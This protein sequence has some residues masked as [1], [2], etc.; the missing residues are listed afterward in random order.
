MIPAPRKALR[1]GASG[2]CTYA[3]FNAVDEGNAGDTGW[4]RDRIGVR[5]A[6]ARRALVAAL[7]STLL[8]SCGIPGPVSAAP[9][10]EAARCTTTAA[11]VN[12]WGTPNRQDDFND[13][14]LP[15]W[16]LYDGPGHD[17][18]GRRTPA[19]VSVTEGTLT[20]TGAPN[21]DSGGMGWDSGQMYGRWEVCARSPQAAPGYHSVL[22]LWPDAEDWPIGG[23]VDFMEAIDPTRQ[24]VE[25][26]LHYGAEDHRVGGAVNV[27]ATQ[28]HSWAVEWTPK[29]IT[30]YLNGN[31]WWTTTDIATFPPRALH[32]CLQVDN[33][34]G[35]IAA[36]GQQL[37]DWVRQYPLT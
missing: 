11:A 16:H 9:P 34:G 30:M 8:A 21:G 33:F 12:G 6:R 26:W 3:V 17:G 18:N 22:L 1:D 5:G 25:G 23:E 4:Y 24:S 20:I 36:G 31:P 19:A 29:M 10:E 32:L 7:A 35:D 15:G 28:W 27:D 2:G 37:V 14:R 13:P